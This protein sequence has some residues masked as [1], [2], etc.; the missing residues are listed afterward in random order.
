MGIRRRQLCVGVALVLGAT[1]LPA[2]AIAQSYGEGAK[3]AGDHQMRPAGAHRP[4]PAAAHHRIS[5]AH[6]PA[7][8]AHLMAPKHMK[9]TDS[10]V[11]EGGFGS[12]NN[13]GGSVIGDD[14]VQ[15]HLHGDNAGG[16]IH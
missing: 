16:N 7:P 10:G 2:S 11:V 5:Q 1:L 12:G 4:M 6:H 9:P 15:G 8:A 13:S 14:A 3:G